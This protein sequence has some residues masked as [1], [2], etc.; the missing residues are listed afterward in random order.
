MP[1]STDREISKASAMTEIVEQVS[2]GEEPD[3][4]TTTQII[5][6]YWTDCLDCYVFFPPQKKELSV[7]Q[8]IQA[9]EDWTIRSI[10]EEGVNK[11]VDTW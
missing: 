6:K 3:F 8:L 5:E 11:M 9:P 7:Y 2:A 10:E 1:A 4:D